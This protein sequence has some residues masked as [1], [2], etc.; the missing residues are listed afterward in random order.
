MNLSIKHF[1]KTVED[2]RFVSRIYKE[3]L[4]L[5]NQKK[6]TTQLKNSQNT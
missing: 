6:Q 1:I 3:L 2:K 5:H 4:K